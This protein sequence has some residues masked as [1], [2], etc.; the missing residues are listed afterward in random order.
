MFLELIKE[1]PRNVSS[2]R[3]C[4]SCKNVQD[5]HV[6]FIFLIIFSDNFTEENN[7]FYANNEHG[8]SSFL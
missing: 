8:I 5:I 6:M 2:W 3:R 7:M 4:L 1:T